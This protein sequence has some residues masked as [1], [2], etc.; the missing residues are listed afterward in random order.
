MDNLASAFQQVQLAA[1][2]ERTRPEPRQLYA[3]ASA[4]LGDSACFSYEDFANAYIQ[5]DGNFPEVVAFLA[6]KPLDSMIK[7]ACRDAIRIYF[8]NFCLEKH[9]Y[10]DYMVK[11]VDGDGWLFNDIKKNIKVGTIRKLETPGQHSRNSFFIALESQSYFLKKVVDIKKADNEIRAYRLAKDMGLSQYLLPSCILEFSKSSGSAER[12]LAFPIM[13]VN[14]LSM[15]DTNS[16]MPGANDGIIKHL[17]DSGEAFKLGLFDYLISNQ[18]RHRNNIFIN[19]GQLTLIDHTEAFEKKEKGFIPGY[20]RL[21]DFKIN[22]TIPECPNDFKLL[23]WLETV[24]I[25]DGEIAKRMSDIS[26]DYY[27]PSKTINELWLSYYK[28]SA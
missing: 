11:F 22:K 21:S 18:D 17:I 20:L 14:A 10:S 16:K 6:K 9:D 4:L 23:E 26:F 15:E 8:P 7:L 5:Y 28:E 25:S 12:Y 19:N 1:H 27:H 3:L 13:S 2:V 24:D